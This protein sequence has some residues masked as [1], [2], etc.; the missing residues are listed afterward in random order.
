M[1]R[2]YRLY[3]NI[4]GAGLTIRTVSREFK[5]LTFRDFKRII[6]VFNITKSSVP[7]APHIIEENSTDEVAN[8]ILRNKENNI[9]KALENDRSRF[10]ERSLVGAYKTISDLKSNEVWIEDVVKKYIDKPETP[11]TNKRIKLQKDKKQNKDLGS[12]AFIM[13]SDIHFGKSFDRT[14]YGRGS[15][16]E[17]LHERIMQIADYTIEDYK[18]RNPSEIILISGGDVIET[19]MSDGMHPGHLY[20]MDLFMEEQI[21]FACD[22]IKE[23]ILKIKE[24]TSCPI[25]IN[26]CSGNHERVAMLR[27]EDKNRTAGKIISHI[28]KR[29]LESQNI[30]FNIP[31][32]N[33]IKIISGN[34][35]MF[36]QH[37]DT[38][39]H[40]KRPTE[41][42]NLYGERGKYNVLLK[43]HWHQ[44]KA[45]EGTNYLSIA[46]PSVCS[47]DAFVMEELGN[48]A[49][50]GF[51]IGHE[52][53][54]GIG[55]DYKKITLY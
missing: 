42:I 3:S 31:S 38:S 6:R 1:D 33:L 49:L 7:V 53:S 26:F 28:L 39:L 46:L 11:S 36:V 44:L 25:S 43:G 55:F 10:F 50:P 18:Q 30:K 24:N 8:L 51:I 23:M 9:L 48:N 5:N 32:N 45:E 15:S 40:K 19:A 29:E 2:V 34:L 16:K 52:S 17:I 13:F 37:G 54:S 47:T 41:L 21:F 27:T 4:E 14:T 12:P 22:S 20:E 35:C